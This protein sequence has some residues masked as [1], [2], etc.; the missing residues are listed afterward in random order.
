MLRIV[1]KGRTTREALHRIELPKALPDY[2]SRS[3]AR[4]VPVNHGVLA[5][6]VVE[7]A[8]RFGL[9]TIA[10]GWTTTRNG[11]G[12]LGALTFDRPKGVVLPKGV[13]L[14]LGV[15][16]SNDGYYAMSFMVG[17][18]VVVCTNG[19]IVSEIRAAVLSRKHT[20]GVELVSV[21]QRGIERF[22]HEADG[23]GSVVKSLED[24]ELTDPQAQRLIAQA[25]RDGVMP[26]SMLGAVDEEWRS[27]THKEFRERNA[28]SL[29][30]AFTK[31]AQRRPPACQMNT[32]NGARGLL[33][34][35]HALV[36]VNN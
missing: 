1:G 25:G 17:A 8:E 19:L 33:L 35:E 32:I 27:P 5:D 3:S 22:M 34:D 26:W 6:T 10:E 14:C 31:V 15:R 16:H 21:V 2:R 4:W 18:T 9:K 24:R 36:A 13:Q 11:L 20:K 23:I 12:M 28:W 30:N 29:Y 7:Q